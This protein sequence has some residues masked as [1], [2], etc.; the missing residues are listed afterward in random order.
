M[1][2]CLCR[3]A[4]PHDPRVNPVITGLTPDR[5]SAMPRPLG[6]TTT[7]TYR[8]HRPSG[9]AVITIDGRDFYL[10]PYGAKAS[11]D[12]YDRLIGEWLASGRRLTALR[13]VVTVEVISAFWKHV[14]SYYGS[15]GGSDGEVAS[16]WL[17]L[18]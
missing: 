10:G 17:A 14:K 8:H 1:R 4:R 15:P 7:P 9:R 13:G 18:A 11:R 16:Y 2:T 5:R 6:S 12:V 3:A